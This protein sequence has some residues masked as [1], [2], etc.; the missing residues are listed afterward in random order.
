M[1]N[2]ICDKSDQYFTYERHKFLY[3]LSM[4]KLVIDKH[5][6]SLVTKGDESTI[7]AC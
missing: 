1:E 7:M 3:F 5:N 6:K 2:D 4:A